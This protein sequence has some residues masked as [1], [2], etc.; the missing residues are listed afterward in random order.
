MG[1]LTQ[2]LT[3]GTS[4]EITGANNDIAGGSSD[5]SV[6]TNNLTTNVNTIVSTNIENPYVATPRQVVGFNPL[7][8]C[9][10]ED[11][12]LSPQLTCYFNPVFGNGKGASY[13]N[14][15]TPF[16]IDTGGMTA[17]VQFVVQKFYDDYWTPGNSN[18]GNWVNM[19]TI[20][21]NTYGAYTK[22][23]ALAAHP[24][25]MGFTADWGLITTTFGEGI[26]RIMVE[27]QIGTTVTQPTATIVIPNTGF[28]K[29][30]SGTMTIGDH[31]YAVYYNGNYAGY[32]LYLAGL[33]NSDIYYTAVVTANGLIITG[34]QGAAQ[35]GNK[36]I[37]NLQNTANM[38]YAEINTIKPKPPLTTPHYDISSATANGSVSIDNKPQPFSTVFFNYGNCYSATTW[39]YT[40]TGTDPI[41]TFSG[42]LWFWGRTALAP[43]FSGSSLTVWLVI[44][45]VRILNTQIVFPAATYGFPAANGI[46]TEAGWVFPPTDGV[47]GHPARLR[48]GDVVEL[49][50]F[51]GA[52]ASINSAS[53]LITVGNNGGAWWNNSSSYTQTTLGTLAGGVGPTGLFGCGLVS[54]PYL[55]RK[56]D[57]LK[58]DGTTKFEV[59]LMNEVGDIE[60]PGSLF[61]L[62]GMNLYDSI[63][64]RGKFHKPE[65]SYDELIL[66]YG[67]GTSQ[68]LGFK[69]RIHDKVI[70]SYEWEGFDLPEYVHDRFA[71][72]GLTA[73]EVYVSD[74]NF[75]NPSY[76]IKEFL[77]MKAGDYKA[78]YLDDGRFDKQNQYR[79]RLGCVKVKFKEGV[80]SMLISNYFQ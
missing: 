50:I 38:F 74:Y 57:C 14:D 22:L 44:N 20:A 78:E 30:M 54:E 4:G 47:M 16:W 35:N 71:K 6:I 33:I 36:V 80:E 68:L 42:R 18:N 79:A 10:N 39:K 65:M 53:C 8:S 56:W 2:L 3:K 45:G 28:P 26:Y 77:V 41:Q 61:D 31:V 5:I 48:A 23:L 40:A 12:R 58:A 55:A 76:D 63:R 49:E 34:T 1:T 46:T 13:E 72:Y 60:N 52:S 19:A 51:A 64:M 43:Y 37:F 69:E 11:C 73:A 27:T 25:Y 24:T 15:L 75:L 29:L 7:T 59:Y 67:Q 62:T 66:E 17:V 70:T 32:L 21:D 9:F